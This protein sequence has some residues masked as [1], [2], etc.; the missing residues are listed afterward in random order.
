M[1]EINWTALIT[2]L[3]VVCAV[4]VVGSLFTSSSVESEWYESIKPSITPPN[5]VFPVVW[6]ILFFLIALSLYIVWTSANKENK[7]KIFICY[8]INFVFNIM[9]S[10]S[11]FGLKD[12][13]AA[14]IDLIFL[15]L[16]VLYILVFSWKID[17]R[18][19]YLLIPYLLWVGFAGILNY[20]SISSL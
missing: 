18:A 4:A 7:G 14:F 11:Y 9:W 19:S 2:S 6:S 17:R 12:P 8:G 3:I 13:L 1:R 16:S 20:L 15:F 10:V 5:W